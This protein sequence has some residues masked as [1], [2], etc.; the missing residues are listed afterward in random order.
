VDNARALACS[1]ARALDKSVGISVAPSLLLLRNLRGNQKCTQ[2]FSLDNRASC[3]FWVLFHEQQ[4][5]GVELSGGC[6]FF[7]PFCQMFF[8]SFSSSSPDYKTPVGIY[9]SMGHFAGFFI[10]ERI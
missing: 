9:I 1:L 5:N 8:S 3:R 10:G 7:L 2:N 6:F 4:L